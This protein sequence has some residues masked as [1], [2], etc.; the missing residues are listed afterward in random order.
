MWPDTRARAT[1]SSTEICQSVASV[2]E[3]A[4]GRNRGIVQRVAKGAKL[5]AAC[6]R[7]PFR[8]GMFSHRRH[9]CAVALL[10]FLAAAIGLPAAPGAI[11]LVPPYRDAA[12]GLCTDAAPIFRAGMD[13]PR[14]GREA[15]F[16]LAAALLNVQPRTQGNVRE[17]A[18]LLAQVAA[19]KADDEL[20]IAAAYLQ[21]RVAQI[22]LQPPDPA[23]ALQ[24]Y[25]SLYRAHPEHP[26]GQMS[27]VKAATLRLYDPATAPGPRRAAFDEA[28]Q[29]LLTLTDHD[30]IR[31]GHSLL[32]AVCDRFD[33]GDGLRLKHLLAQ[34]AAGVARPDLRLDVAL[35]IA[36]TARRAGQTD[37]AA[38]HYQNFLDLAPRD[39]RR[40]SVEQR[41]AQLSR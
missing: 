1:R 7:L 27:F 38:A 19:A 23:M 10:V 39:Y 13:D 41:L 35:S 21:A 5:L 32:A 29:R 31:D 37:V 34:E 18:A 26:L 4:P 8:A 20:G 14:S 9:P 28:E 24:R 3:S 36:E 15:Q 16:G 40:F 2:R 30:A 33:Y 17:A 25:Q 11:D 12:L 22:H 6:R